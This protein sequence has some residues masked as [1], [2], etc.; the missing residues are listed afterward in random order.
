MIPDSFKHIINGTFVFMLCTSLISC[1]FQTEQTDAVLPVAKR[2]TAAETVQ[3]NV[4]AP[5]SE[6]S[7]DEQEQVYEYAIDPYAVT[8]G[9]RDTLSSAACEA[10]RKTVDAILAAAET[11]GM[12]ER[13][14]D[15]VV[16]ALAECFPLVWLAE[17]LTFIP[18]TTQTEETDKPDEP[19]DESAAD[20]FLHITYKHDKQEH[21]EKV[22]EFFNRTA[23]IMNDSG[24]AAA[25]TKETA[26]ILLFR[27][28][29]K[30]VTDIAG[31]RTS[32]YDAL[33]KGTDEAAGDIKYDGG[34]SHA[35]AYI[36][37][38]LQAGVDCTAVTGMFYDSPRVMCAVMIGSDLFYCDPAGEMS[39]S[40][41]GGLHF[42]GLNDSDLLA[43]GSGSPVE[44]GFVSHSLFN[45][46]HSG[47]EDTGEEEEP[48]DP[49]FILSSDIKR[50][51]VFR[52]SDYF[53][54]K[55]ENAKG[56]ILLY[57]SDFSDPLVY[58]LQ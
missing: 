8:A 32:S 54:Y 41:G 58:N 39:N 43:E 25:S 5:E 29:A 16:S 11:V 49:S 28:T 34:G 3:T 42:F 26:A 31:K 55:N 47:K 56:Q 36:Y 52:N 17:N 15:A 12:T 27:Y 57:Y 48:S 22:A 14:A 37:L 7:A 40:I 2:Q 33:M 23:F 13:H 20:G 21:V 38:L 45:Y 19:D 4:W 10:Y 1:S 18:Y 44:A 35:L 53:E 24:A 50:Y 30:T 6:S 51:E 46:I 9:V